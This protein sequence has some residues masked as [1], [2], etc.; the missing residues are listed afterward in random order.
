MRNPEVRL[1]STALLAIGLPL[2]VIGCSAAQRGSPYALTKMD[3]ELVTA[4]LRE[5]PRAQPGAKLGRVVST[6]RARR[7]ENVVC[8]YIGGTPFMGSLITDEQ[9][10]KSFSIDRNYGVGIAPDLAEVIYRVCD[11]VGADIR[12]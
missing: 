1:I 3:I 8:G 7:N 11:A 5:S 9:N 6:Y 10:K 2:L 12:Q 4:S